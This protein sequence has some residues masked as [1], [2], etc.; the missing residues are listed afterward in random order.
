MWNPQQD[1]LIPVHYTVDTVGEKAK[2]REAL[3]E[4]L[5]LRTDRKPIVAY[6]GR[7]DVQK[8][9]QLIRHALSYTLTCGG[10]FV[11]LGPSSEQRINDEFLHLRYHL[12]DHPDCHL[13]IAFSEELAHVIFAGADLVVVPSLFE[14]CGLTQLIAMRY[15]AVPIVRAVGGLVD[16]V[17]DRDYS[18]RLP[19]ERNGYVFHQPDNPGIESAMQRALGLWFDYPEDFRQLRI[20][21]MRS[22]F[23]WSQPGQHYLNIYEYIRHK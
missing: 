4:R 6:V 20:A 17:F 15:G 11:L 21:G 18:D 9:V 16:T 3:R 23:S 10:Q 19:V 13:E 12:R 2:D 7:L 1:P 22:D 5:W 8:G 14:P